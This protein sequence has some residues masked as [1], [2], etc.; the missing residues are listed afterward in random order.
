VV[1]GLAEMAHLEEAL[2]AE[3]EGPLPPEARDE[4]HAIYAGGQLTR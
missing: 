4:L 1:F 2:T 3:S